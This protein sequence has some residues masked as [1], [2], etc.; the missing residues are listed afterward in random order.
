MGEWRQ[1]ALTGGAAHEINGSLDTI[2]GNM[3]LLLTQLDPDSDARARAWRA[4]DE[5][6][7]IR[8]IV[9]EKTRVSR[10]LSWDRLRAI[11]SLVGGRSARGGHRTR[12]AVAKA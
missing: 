4:L 3:A 2:I 8:E 11:R 1:T 12:S 10:T 9:S 6:K 7:R 5:A